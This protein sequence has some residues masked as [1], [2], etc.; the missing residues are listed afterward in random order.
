M[1]KAGRKHASFAPKQHRKLRK[2]CA[3]R[4]GMRCRCTGT[5]GL[6]IREFLYRFSHTDSRQFIL[7]SNMSSALFSLDGI[8]PPIRLRRN[9]AFS[10]ILF[11]K[12]FWPSSRFDC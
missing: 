4:L 12:M 7:H 2:F 3:V 1:G 9:G 8:K 6:E 5:A 10:L 11:R